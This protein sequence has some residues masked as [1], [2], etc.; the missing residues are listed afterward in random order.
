MT[1]RW[2]R[3]R[4]PRGHPCASRS[5]PPWPW[6]ASGSTASPRA[7]PS[8]SSTGG[9]SSEPP[10]WPP[11]ASPRSGST[12]CSP[13]WRRGKEPKP[14]RAEE[15]PEISYDVSVTTEWDGNSHKDIFFF[16]VNRAYSKPFSVA[17]CQYTVLYKSFVQR[18]L[19][20]LI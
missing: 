3:N 1:R 9:T 18:R 17:Y 15:C 14:T 2:G 16:S 11:P 7:S 5:S 10:A 8:A 6:S 19:R 4:N 12:R 20:K 13:S